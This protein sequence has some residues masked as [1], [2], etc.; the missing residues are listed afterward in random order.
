[1]KEVIDERIAQRL[2]LLQAV[3]VLTGSKSNDAVMISDA[4]RRAGLDDSA[5]T[6]ARA[7]LQEE[8]LLELRASQ[9]LAITHAGVKECEDALGGRITTG[10]PHF[11]TDV[12]QQVIQT[13]GHNDGSVQTGGDGNVSIVTSRSGAKLSEFAPLVAEMRETAQGLAA[14]VR[15]EALA[16]LDKLKTQ[17]ESDKPNHT[18]VTM[19]LKG[20]AE[21]VELAPLANRF[22]EMLAGIGA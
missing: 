16:A 20:L 1:M 22:L 18:L 10:T 3:Y 9:T 7:Y 6:L 8:G 15:H 13:R 2:R 5:G 19:Y 21:F 17:A 14:D 11:P 4:Y 12:I